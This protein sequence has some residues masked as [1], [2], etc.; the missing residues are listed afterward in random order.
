MAEIFPVGAGISE[1]RAVI[2]I[3]KDNDNSHSM[4]VSKL[5]KETKKTIDELLPVIEA[6]AM[7]GFV[8][9]YDGEIR[10][11]KTGT[12]LDIGNFQSLIRK[13]IVKSEPFKTTLELLEANEKLSTRKLAKLLAARDGILFHGREKDNEQLLRHILLRW[14]VR[15]QIMRYDIK[16][17][18][19]T[20]KS[21]HN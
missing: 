6:C 11:T 15:C 14:A 18:E 13:D 16:R 1:M 9:L 10:L 3:V 5:A 19:F 8:N 2:R 7:L 4:P 21:K 17:D 12:Q 20:L